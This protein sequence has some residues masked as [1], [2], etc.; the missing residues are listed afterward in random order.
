VDEIRKW[1]WTVIAPIALLVV[2]LV[3][4]LWL[5]LTSG[6]AEDPEFLGTLGTPVRGT[7]VPSTPT[8]EG[9]QAT[10]RPRPTFAGVAEG[11]PVE[12]DAKRRGD[13]VRL[14]LAANAIRDEDGSYPET[15]GNVQTLCVF[16]DLDQGCRLKDTI[17]GGVLPQDPFGEPIVNGYW[18]SS[19]GDTVK[20][21]A[22][23]ELEITEEERCATDNVDL[24][25]KASLVCIEGP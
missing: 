18:Y 13:L 23:L 5:D 19:D 25:E 9:A 16:E 15:G 6:G 10:P 22:S 11:T 2:A 24:R 8:P 4:I 14:L 7:F 21:Y 1:N 17:E 3:A 20:I 12:R